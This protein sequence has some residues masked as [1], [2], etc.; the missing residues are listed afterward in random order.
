[1][2]QNSYGCPQIPGTESLY[3][4]HDNHESLYFSPYEMLL[5]H[6]SVFK[7]IVSKIEILQQVSVAYETEL[8]L[9][10]IVL[11]RKQMNR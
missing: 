1:L 4:E 11:S 8:H 2:R 10:W 3:D 5:V 9:H 6:M 7:Q